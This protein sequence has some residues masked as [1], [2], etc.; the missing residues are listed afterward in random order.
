MDKLERQVYSAKRC[1]SSRE[2]EGVVR[3]RGLP[4]E[5]FNAEELR[6]IIELTMKQAANERLFYKNAIR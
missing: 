5:H 4:L 1:L 2:Y 6:K 3:F